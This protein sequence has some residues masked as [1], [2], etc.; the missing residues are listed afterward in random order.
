[1]RGRRG[2]IVAYLTPASFLAGDYFKHLRRVLHEQAPPVS[3]DLVESRTNAFED[4]LQE[5][6]LSVFRRG[7]VAGPA[8]CSV[9]TAT[10]SG[11]LDAATGTLVLPVDPEGPWTLPRSTDDTRL[12]DHLREMPTRLADWG[13]EVSTGP[14]VWNRHKPRLHDAPRPG[15]V[16]VVWAEAVTP[17]GRFVLTATRRNHR[18]WFEPR[19]PDDPNPAEP[20]PNRQGFALGRA[21]K[22]W[23]IRRFTSARLFPHQRVKTI[24]TL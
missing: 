12:V 14:L 6:V 24:R 15:R 22:F 10:R 20:E 18:V 4:V 23:M 8:T 21:G 11:M 17:D 9:L 2:G 5:L 19:G 3:V 7:A 16:P 13:Y 1:L